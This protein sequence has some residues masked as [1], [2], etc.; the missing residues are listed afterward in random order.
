MKTSELIEKLNWRYAVKKFDNTKKISDSDWA[1]LE[2]AL[3]LTPSSYGL[4]PWKFLVVQNASLRK[5][6]TPHSWNQ[7]QVEDCSHYVV[8]AAKEKVDSAWVQK[9]IS[10]IAEVRGVDESSLKGYHDMMLGDVV[11]GPRS[12]VA[13]EWASKQVYIALGN[14][15]TA[16]AMLNIDA[17]PMEGIDPAKY[18]EILDLNGSGYIT[19]VSCALGYRSNQDRSASYKKVRF[20]TEDVV[21]YL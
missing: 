14:L 10:R 3:L 7:T 16:A 17:C 18:D 15:M 6:L 1:A 13:K 2:Q 4:Q 21:K 12:Q 5:K 19:L 11:N 9:Y 8:L 20:K